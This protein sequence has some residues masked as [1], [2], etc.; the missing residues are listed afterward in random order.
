MSANLIDLIKGQ[1]GPATISQAAAQFGES[2]S[3]VSKAVSGLIPAVI[4]AMSQHADNSS[5]VDAVMDAP[6]HNFLGNLLGGT[7]SMPLV[8]GI[9]STLFGSKLPEL[10]STVASFAGVKHDT[11]NG[12]LSAVTGASFGTV[13]KYAQGNNL[14]RAG[15]SKLLRAQKSHLSSL[16]PTGLSLEILGLGSIFGGE[17]P[18]IPTVTNESDATAHKVEEST[19]TRA[20]NIHQEPSKGSIWK[21]LIPLLLLL[22]LGY[23]LW[24]SCDKKDAAPVATHDSTAMHKDTVKSAN[25]A[26][27]TTTGEKTL[28]EIDLNGKK[29]KGYANGM[30]YKLATFLKEGLYDKAADDTALKNQW[31]EFDNVTFDMGSSN[32]L[33]AG[34]EE[35]IQNLA[36]ILKA[37]PNA[38]IKIGGYTD[39]VGDAAKNKKLSQ[40]RAD[41]IKA[42][43]TKLGVGAQ[44]IGAEGYG[45]EFATVPA[46]ASDAERAKDRKMAVRFTK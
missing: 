43:L 14:D 39:N 25:Q 40:D 20:G 38:K 2:E 4:G 44:V 28:T 18:S 16:I 22:G 13:G 32:K 8:G 19:V 6:K 29:L 45:S 35:Q 15:V 11:I 27:A 37:Y 34:S 30:E 21:W 46:T 26:P 9:L 33:T 23:F 10:I 31:Y 12:L 7:A 5:V 42:E 24:K 36:E 41:F 3:N 1:L 17:N